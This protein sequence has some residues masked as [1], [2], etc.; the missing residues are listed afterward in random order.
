LG[1]LGTSDESAILYIGSPLFS[2]WLNPNLYLMLM[3]IAILGIDKP[4]CLK[5]TAFLF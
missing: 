3:N 2:G 4:Q 1:V 5:D